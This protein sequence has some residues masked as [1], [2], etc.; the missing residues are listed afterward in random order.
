MKL[1]EPKEPKEQLVNVN[2]NG[3]YEDKLLH[4]R[5]WEI[6]RNIYNKSLDKVEELTKKI[7]GNKSV[8]TTIRTR[9]KRSK[10]ITKG[11]W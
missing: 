6:F 5:E 4:S 8:F 11:F 9:S 1:L 7:D 3:D 2:V 10:R